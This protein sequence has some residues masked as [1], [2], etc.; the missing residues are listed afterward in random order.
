M[1]S[2]VGSYRHHRRTGRQRWTLKR[3]AQ[4]LRAAWQRFLANLAR[5][6]PPHDPQP[7]P[8]LAKAAPLR[9]GALLSEYVDARSNK[10]A[11]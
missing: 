4:S 5:H 8:P 1:N 2:I 9:E 6:V 3:L 11:A 7:S 10:T